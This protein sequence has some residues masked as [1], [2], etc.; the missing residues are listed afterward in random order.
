MRCPSFAPKYDPK[1]LMCVEKSV[2]PI[3]IENIFDVEMPD[4]WWKVFK[5]VFFTFKD[6]IAED[7]R[8]TSRGQADCNESSSRFPDYHP[9]EEEK[10]NCANLFGKWNGWL[11]GG[12]FAYDRNDVQFTVWCIGTFG[13]GTFDSIA[14]QDK[15]SQSGP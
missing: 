7:A 11:S 8:N 12:D 3:A 1:A 14:W 2:T 9:T 5:Y 15:L 6:Q 13:P 4:S 10:T